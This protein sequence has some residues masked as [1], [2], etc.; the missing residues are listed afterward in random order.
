MTNLKKMLV[1][2]DPR[3]ENDHSPA[4]LAP[5]PSTLN[6]KTLG[7]LSNNK[8]HSE[9]LLRMI[10]AI[11]KEMYDIEGTV[12]YNKGSHQWPANSEALKEFATKCDVAIHA[13]AE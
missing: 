12:E 8:P 1:T 10:S 4:L 11:M 7:L 13:T 9:E 3:D 5:R 6:G 2:L